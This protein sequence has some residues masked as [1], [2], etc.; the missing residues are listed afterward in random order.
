MAL[1]TEQY[2]TVTRLLSAP[3]G[4]D[5]REPK[6]DGTDRRGSRR[7]QARG[8]AEM[9]VAPP[10]GAARSTTVYVHDISTGGVG[11]LSGTALR[12]G[13]VVE[14][15][16]SNGHD[17]ITLRCDVVHCTPLSV[18]LWGLGVNVMEFQERRA[19]PDSPAAEAA[20]AWAGFFTAQSTGETTGAA[21]P[22]IP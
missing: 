11:L 4:R 8:P 18:G 22:T 10:N 1:T 21:D 17:D 5:A 3:P 19:A 14:I 13:A 7:A 16:F 9:R 20:A 12:T 2:K 6:H 15:A